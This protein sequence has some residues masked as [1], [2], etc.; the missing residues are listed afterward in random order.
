MARALA[1]GALAALLGVL[2]VPTRADVP[3]PLPEQLGS[4]TPTAATLGAFFSDGRGTLDTFC[5]ARRDCRPAAEKAAL[6]TLF[7]RGSFAQP[8]GDS[9]PKAEP[10][11]AYAAQAAAYFT[12][13]DYA[14]R[15]PL[16]ARVLETLWQLPP[17][18][19]QCPAAVPFVIDGE[20]GSRRVQTVEPARVAAV[21]L[22]FAGR[23]DRAF[24]LSRFGH[25]GLRLVVCNAARTET[26]AACD[27][28]LFDHLAFG[29]RAAVDELELSW[30]KGITGGYALRLYGGPF[31]QA[32]GNYTQD[33]FRALSSLPLQLEPAQRE[34]LVRGLAEVQWSY[35]NDY[36]FFSQNCASEIAW[37]LQVV[38]Q[39]SGDRRAWLAGD[40]VRPDR[41]YARALASPAFEGRVLADLKQAER[42]GFHFPGAA[43]YYQHALDTLLQRATAAGVALP[44]RDFNA[45]RTLDA[46]A[47][48]RLYAAILAADVEA[49]SLPTRERA[50]HAALVLE[51]WRE[52]RQRRQ[53]W[54][55][56]A[57]FYAELTRA[58]VT[59]TDYFDAAERALLRRC[60]SAAQAAQPLAVDG[61]PSEPTVAESGC[62]YKAA[63]FQA[64][65]A[66]LLQ[67]AAPG[68]LQQEQVA[69]LQATV[70]IVNWLLPQTGLATPATPAFTATAAPL[71]PSTADQMG[72]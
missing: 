34:L 7:F 33:E 69:A 30:W 71:L 58:L 52:R 66:K 37:L 48:R 49:G 44:A 54:S 40:F 42:D 3:A 32:Y 15:R 67:V 46:E 59:E 55:A 43:P 10:D 8:P 47:R 36:H 23:D 64:A 51:A 50:A 45:F 16:T 62:P 41:L 17:A 31:M 65:L 6:Y 26:G 9:L 57:R 56:M 22:L 61:V 53:L 39:V 27:E 4:T 35:V 38:S 18:S 70:D 25:T 1:A 20:D 24:S 2:A 14:C 12:Q 11:R 19:V 63:D 60:L 72:N 29:F 68:E 5:A 21:H 28:D 13:A